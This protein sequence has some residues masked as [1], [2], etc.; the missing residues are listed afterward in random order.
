MNVVNFIDNLEMSR[1]DVLQHTGGP[2]FQSLGKDGVVSVS[3]SPGTDIP[4]IGPCQP[5]NINQDTHQFWDGQ[6]GMSVIQLQSN[7]KVKNKSSII[8]L[9]NI[10]YKNF[11]YRYNNNVLLPYKTF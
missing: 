9:T 5:F 10:G 2:A 3:T 7:L 4:S 1:K 6:R 8:S 11:I